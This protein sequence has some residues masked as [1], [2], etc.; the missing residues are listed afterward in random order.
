[1]PLAGLLHVDRSE[2]H[3]SEAVELLSKIYSGHMSAEFTHLEVL[4]GL[5]HN[6]RPIGGIL[7][8][9]T[10]QHENNENNDYQSGGVLIDELVLSL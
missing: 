1:M 10:R 2:A 5:V 7:I 3:V 9:T 4:S 8:L 6:P